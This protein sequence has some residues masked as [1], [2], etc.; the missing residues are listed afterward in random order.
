MSPGELIRETRRELRLSQRQLAFRAE[1]TQAAISRIEQAK[2]SPSYATLRVLMN[3]MGREP[4]VSAIPLDADFDAVHLRSTLA[5][6][7][8]ERLRLAIGW[9]RL[10]AR[11]ATAGEEARAGG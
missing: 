4:S 9:N 6:S 2:I 8:E 5:R 11:L 7:P 10:A 1:T 3:A